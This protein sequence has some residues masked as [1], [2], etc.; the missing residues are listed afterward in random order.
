MQGR[1][2]SCICDKVIHSSKASNSTLVVNII[3]VDSQFSHEERHTQSELREQLNT[4]DYIEDD[5]FQ[6]YGRI[7]PLEVFSLCRP[8]HSYW[9]LCVGRTLQFKDQGGTLR[10]CRVS[11]YGQHR[12]EGNGP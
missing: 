10:D 6:W 4:L 11:E 3:A 9:A 12:V 1:G 8:G 7:V 2:H 5:E